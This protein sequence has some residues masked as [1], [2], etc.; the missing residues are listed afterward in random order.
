[1]ST[2]VNRSNFTV[3]GI[4]SNGFIATPDVVCRERRLNGLRDAMTRH[5]VGGKLSCTLESLADLV[6][7]NMEKVRA[8]LGVVNFDASKLMLSLFRRIRDIKLVDMTGKM[9]GD[10]EMMHINGNV[11][12]VANSR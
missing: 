1:M 4:R 12:N 9:K 5:D 3:N 10:L 6:D 7:V 8:E 11:F 2:R